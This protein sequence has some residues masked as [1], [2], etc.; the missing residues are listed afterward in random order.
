MTLPEV[1]SAGGSSGLITF[2]EIAKLC[3]DRWNRTILENEAWDRREWITLGKL[4]EALFNNRLGHVQIES[5]GMTAIDAVERSG[6]LS[7]F[8]N[9]RLQQWLGIKFQLIGGI[10]RRPPGWGKFVS[11]DEAQALADAYIRPCRISRP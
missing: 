4:L 3:A 10:I 6:S 11:S 1:I 7:N 5:Y 8:L 2:G 9:E